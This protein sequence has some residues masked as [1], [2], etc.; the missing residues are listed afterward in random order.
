MNRLNRSAY[1]WYKLIRH[2]R[3]GYDEAF[4]DSVEIWHDCIKIRG[5]IRYRG[6]RRYEIDQSMLNAITEPSDEII[7]S[8]NKRVKE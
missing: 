3:S 8:W 2:Q 6:P 5:A 4:W 7:E 1:E